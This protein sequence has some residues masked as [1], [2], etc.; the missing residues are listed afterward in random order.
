[1]PEIKKIKW[2]ATK[3]FYR[4]KASKSKVV[5]NVGGS[6]SSKSYSISQLFVHRFINEKNKS[7]LSCRKTF[8]ALR[9]TALD[10]A[11]KQLIEIG[12]MPYLEYNKSE[13]IIR[14]KGNKNE[15]HFKSI[16]DPQKIRSTE[17]NYI[18]MEEANEFS[19]DDYQ[20]L[21]LR[22]SG[23]TGAH[24]IN[25]VFM[26]L[27]PSDY[28]SWIKERLI[29]K[30]DCEIIHSTYLDNLRFLPAEYV[31]YLERLKTED[32]SYWK[33]YGLGEW[34]IVKGLIYTNFQIVNELPP[35][36]H[37]TIYG[38]DF[39]FN[40]PTVLLEINIYDAAVGVRELIHEQR[41]TNSEF[42]DRMKSVII[43][44]HRKRSIY[45]DSA[46][47][48]RIA[49][50]SAAGFNVYPAH[51]GSGVKTGVDFCKRYKI[52]S[53]PESYKSN[54]E[55]QRYKWKIDRNGNVLDEPVKYDDHAPDAFRYGVY[56]HLKDA[57]QAGD[58]YFKMT[59]KPIIVYGERY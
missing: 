17:F 11:V 42:I 54:D 51:K 24:E 10:V 27:N 29:D 19:Y 59:K 25:Q 53:T 23:K 20:M 58:A 6:R 45:A 2:P 8:P 15:W 38:V 41:M 39:G 9:T 18:H 52:L 36:P 35:N 12:V 44:F 13:H 37:E 31:Q 14:N 43:P 40:N 30:A 28:R 49:E 26:S 50:I 4:N 34:A 5:T 56:S 32:E 16:D 7:F 47:P 1:M 55:F 48:D 46:E 22:L 57:T 21:M 3:I 33:I